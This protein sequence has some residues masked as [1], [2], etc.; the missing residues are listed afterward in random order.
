MKSLS[1]EV[2]DQIIWREKTRQSNM[3][4][5]SNFNTDAATA[6]KL[7]A[8]FINAMKYTK[9]FWQE[10]KRIEKYGQTGE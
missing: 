7:L 6:T 10:W 1:F 3:L 2:T 9:I 8:V 4:G 5:L